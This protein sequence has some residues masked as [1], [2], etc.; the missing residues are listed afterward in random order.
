VHESVRQRAEALL[1]RRDAGR[2][3][4]RGADAVVGGLPGKDHS[5]LRRALRVPREPHELDR[6]LDA[7]G[8]AVREEDMVEPGRRELG[9]LRGEADR[10]FVGEVP[11][12]RVEL[13]CA[14]LLGGDV[15]ELRAPVPDGALPEPARAVDV[16]LSLVVPEQRALPARPDDRLLRAADDGVRVNDVRAVELRQSHSAFRTVFKLVYSSIVSGPCS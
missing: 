4:R 7:L 11:E 10:R 16:L 2:G 13:E 5:A 1:E 3:E 8:A 9:E 12:R 6:R 14:H 15:R